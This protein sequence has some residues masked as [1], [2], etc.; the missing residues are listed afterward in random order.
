MFVITI[1]V[2]LLMIHSSR[3]AISATAVLY[4]DNSAVPHG[5]LTFTQ[6]NA[7]AYVHIT[8]SLIGLNASS[9]HVCLTKKENRCISLYFRGFIFMYIQ[10]QMVHPIV[11][12][13]ALIL[14][15]IVRQEIVQFK[16]EFCFFFR[17]YSWSTYTQ[18]SKSAC[19]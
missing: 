9:A 15:L 13:L 6:D 8:G 14:I 7:N 17:Y 11:L 12:L 18:Y 4:G 19:W 2:L 10:S 16:Y 1:G 5:T 3:G